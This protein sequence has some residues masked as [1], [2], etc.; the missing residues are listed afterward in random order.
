[1]I[2]YSVVEDP[3]IPD[4]LKQGLQS[5]CTYCGKPM[6]SGHNDFGRITGLRCSDMNCPSMIASRVVF[7]FELIGVKGYGFAKA[8]SMVK[9][10]Q[11]KQAIECLQVLEEPPTV[12][13]GTYL[14]CNCI[15]GIDGEW[16][17]M[18]EKSDSYTLDELLIH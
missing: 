17:S 11:W 1:M 9:Q 6:L 5:N 18:V 13:L 15:Q 10:Y 8:F 4:W 14:R 7:I 3:S 16:E 2:W 12:S